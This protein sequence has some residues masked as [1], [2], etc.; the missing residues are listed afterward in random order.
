MEKLKCAVVGATG[1]AGQKLVA[2]LERHPFLEVARVVASESSAGKRLAD[3]ITPFFQKLD[4]N[5]PS[6]RVMDMVVQGIKNFDPKEC[7]I[8]F[9]TLDSDVAAKY[10]ARFAEDTPVFTAASANRYASLV[11]I[12]NVTVNDEHMEMV[13][14]QKAKF[15][16]RGFIVSK[17]NCTTSPIVSVLKKVA[18]YGIKNVSVSTEQALS[19]AGKKGLEEGNAYRSMVRKVGKYPY[20]EGENEK[21]MS[22][23]KQVL[24]SFDAI[25]TMRKDAD[26]EISAFCTRVYRENVHDERIL[27]RMKNSFDL[28]EILNAILTPTHGYSLYTLPTNTI[29]LWNGKVVPELHTKN[30]GPMATAIGEIKKA[31]ENTLM[32]RATT[33][34]TGIG[35][36]LGLVASAE[37]AIAKGLI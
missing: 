21:V 23:S 19:G 33:D 16:R 1:P 12:H 37:Y 3:A 2:Y 14:A 36:G 35:A 11:P 29:V 7:E 22:E 17:S 32:F 24:G 15:G 6:T 9:S 30:F 10:E 25:N 26:F 34:N 5:V 8:I 27:V 28:G 4:S 20:I 31:D 18:H 13:G